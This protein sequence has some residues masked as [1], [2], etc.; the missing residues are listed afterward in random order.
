MKAEHRITVEYREG[1]ADWEQTAKVTLSTPQVIDL[2][3]WL[4]VTDPAARAALSEMERQA[5]LQGI[6]VLDSGLSIA[7]AVPN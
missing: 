6:A 5:I 1:E 4:A 7:A 3:M 2:L